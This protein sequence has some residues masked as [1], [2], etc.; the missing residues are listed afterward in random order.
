MQA[1]EFETTP[2]ADGSLPVPDAVGRRLARGQPIRVI[3]MV[4]DEAADWRQATER[5]FLAGYAE[6]DSI[7]DDATLPGLKRL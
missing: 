2:R 5:E 6:A 4:Q 3:V 7:Y 1:Y